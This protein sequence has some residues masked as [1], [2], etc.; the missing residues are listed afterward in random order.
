MSFHTYLKNI[1]EKTGVS[2][3]AFINLATQKGF[4][5]N[6]KLKAEIK[7]NQIINWLKEDYQLGH[8]HAQ[9]VYAYIK[10]KRD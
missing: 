6:N 2:P 10:G 8:G 9:A 4:I 1:E 7:A 5:E 3:E